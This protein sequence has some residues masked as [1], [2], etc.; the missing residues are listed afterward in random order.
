MK[1]MEP[2]TERRQHNLTVAKPLDRSRALSDSHPV[3][4]A[5]AAETTWRAMEM[6]THS[7]KLSPPAAKA[8]IHGGFLHLGTLSSTT[9]FCSDNASD[10]QSVLPSGCPTLLHL[11]DGF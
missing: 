5:A 10:V 9:S 6:A 4:P 11:S 8:S 3:L 2:T 1:S 7:W